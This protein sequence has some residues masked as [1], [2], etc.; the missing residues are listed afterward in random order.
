MSFEQIVLCSGGAQILCTPLWC[1]VLQDLD[2]RG[3]E[4]PGGNS[5]TFFKQ[6]YTKRSCKLLKDPSAN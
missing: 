1:R 2:G 4:A 3:E 6:S 5:R